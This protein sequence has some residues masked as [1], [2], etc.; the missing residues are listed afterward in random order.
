[1]P[2]IVND[3]HRQLSLNRNPEFGAKTSYMNTLSQ[4]PIFNVNEKTFTYLNIFRQFFLSFFLMF[5]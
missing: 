1:M 2:T 4:T 5:Y 3:C